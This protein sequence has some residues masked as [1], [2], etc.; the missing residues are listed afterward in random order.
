MCS[1]RQSKPL[2]HE[3][4]KDDRERDRDSEKKD[5]TENKLYWCVL[6]DEGDIK[7]D[8]VDFGRHAPLFEFAFRN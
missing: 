2:I 6:I 5:D 1:F 8:V 7:K 3:Y 4:M